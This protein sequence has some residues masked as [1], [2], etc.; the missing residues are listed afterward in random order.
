[1]PRT[2]E[3]AQLTSQFQNTWLATILL[4]TLFKDNEMELLQQFLGPTS[5]PI[6]HNQHS[7]RSFG[8]QIYSDRSRLLEGIRGGEMGLEQEL[9]MGMAFGLGD[10]EEQEKEM[11]EF[12]GV[13]GMA[14]QEIRYLAPRVPIPRSEYLFTHHVS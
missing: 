2:S 12:I 11:E 7:L 1:M 8:N 13:L 10:S 3:K 9:E 5:K 14:L 6:I 4:N